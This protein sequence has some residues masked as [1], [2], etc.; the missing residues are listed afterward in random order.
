MIPIHA[1]PMHI[2]ECPHTLVV[3]GQSAR[4]RKALGSIPERATDVKTG[5]FAL[6]SLVHGTNKL[7][8]RMAGS[9]SV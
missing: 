7:G 2:K 3:R 9:E 5:R 6:L 8:N 4:L 1:L